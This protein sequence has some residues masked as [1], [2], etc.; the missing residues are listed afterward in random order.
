MGERFCFVLLA[1]MES[2][3]SLPVSGFSMLLLL[4]IAT[5]L[6]GGLNGR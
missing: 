1:I 6:Y 2:D 5:L 4:P 3:T